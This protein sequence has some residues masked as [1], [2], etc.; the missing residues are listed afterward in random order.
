MAAIITIANQKGGVGKTATANA[1]TDYYKKLGYK[2]LMVDTD[3][4]C[5]TSVLYGAQI[6]N[7][8]TLC[9]L[10][11]Q[12][13]R[14]EEAIQKTKYGDI[15]ACDPQ[16]AKADA[17]F[18]DYGREYILKEVLE[19]AKKEYDLIFI[20]TSP[21]LGIL[22]FNALV[23][24]DGVVIPICADSDS[25]QGIVNL[26]NTIKAVQKHSNSGLTIYGLLVTML[27]QNTS[28]AKDIINEALPKIEDVTGSKV[29]ETKIRY[30]TKV[31][32]AK[33]KKISLFEYA[34]QCTAAIDYSKIGDELLKM[35]ERE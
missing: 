5:N 28:L 20:D 17:M 22:L 25:L 19:P 11:M 14:L 34:P 33:A 30:T 16:L 18:Q 10:L 2:T 15:I 8:A 7:Q 21:S 6:E 27:F 1:L 35:V 29:F 23:A 31:K 12:D 26:S 24:A 4:Q 3:P 32:E 9:D 13:A